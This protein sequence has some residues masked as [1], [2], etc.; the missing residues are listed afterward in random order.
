M[1]VGVKW[2]HASL[3][4]IAND[5]RNEERVIPK[6]ERGTQVRLAAMDHSDIRGSADWLPNFITSSRDCLALTTE[7]THRTAVVLSGAPCRGAR[8]AIA[9]GS[10][11][12]H[13]RQ[14][15]R[16]HASASRSPTGNATPN[17]AMRPCSW[18]TSMLRIFLPAAAPAPLV[19]LRLWERRT[20]FGGVEPLPRLPRHPSHLS[21]LTS[22]T[23]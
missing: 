22:Q 19:A 20:A 4:R 21:Y 14:A 1:A 7:I 10:D 16:P 3:S 18:F 12:A 5:R 6:Q 17:S 11:S 8:C 2:R 13:H 9:L 23:D 15:V